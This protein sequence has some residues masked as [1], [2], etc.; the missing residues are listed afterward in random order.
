MLYTKPNN[1]HTI[2]NSCQIQ[3]RR[4][5]M[6][7]QRSFRGSP[8][9]ALIFAFAFVL[10]SNA[11][12]QAISLTCNP[13]TGPVKVGVASS[14]TCTVSGGT[15]PYSFGLNPAN[16]LPAGLTFAAATA[17]TATITGTPTTAG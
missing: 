7:N 12:G 15:P 17:T 1:C 11:T 9:A 2:D 5:S 14:T 10:L 6:C 3:L 16:Q 8:L 4:I 13:S